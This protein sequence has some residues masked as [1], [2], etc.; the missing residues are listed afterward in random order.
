MGILLLCF[1]TKEGSIYLWGF[2]SGILASKV[3]GNFVCS[4]HYFVVCE[5]IHIERV[6]DIISWPKY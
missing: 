5:C 2:A 4:L 6:P 1:G 3:S